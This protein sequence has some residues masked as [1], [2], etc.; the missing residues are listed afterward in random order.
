M[1]TQGF[2]EEL[3]L[4]GPQKKIIF[5]GFWSEHNFFL[6]LPIVKNG[7]WFMEILVSLLKHFHSWYNQNLFGTEWLGLIS[8]PNFI[9]SS[10]RH[11]LFNRIRK[12]SKKGDLF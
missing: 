7:M 8:K 6:Q 2:S 4:L 10:K 9:W 11:F 5:L 3:D 12:S 1:S